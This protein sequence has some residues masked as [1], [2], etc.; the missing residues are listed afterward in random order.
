M[1][2][3]QGFALGIQRGENMVG[4]TKMN[5][6]RIVINADQIEI[7]ETTPDTV[8][9]MTN[10]HKYIVMENAEEVVELIVKY[11]QRIFNMIS[12]K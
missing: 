9:T 1:N 3:T 10:G 11:K 7:I 8:I 6:H 12:D 4:L 5:Q 2:D